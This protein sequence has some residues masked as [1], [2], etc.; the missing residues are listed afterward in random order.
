[1]ILRVKERLLARRD[2]ADGARF[3]I[4]GEWDDS[5]PVSGRL[6]REFA[7]RPGRKGSRTGYLRTAFGRNGSRGR[8]GY[9]RRNGGRNP[10]HIWFAV[11]LTE[12]RPEPRT[13][14]WVPD[15]ADSDQKKRYVSLCSAQGRG[16]RC[17]S[18]KCEGRSYRDDGRA[19][20]TYGSRE[21]NE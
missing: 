5:L 7:G 8:G 1:M 19:I 2:E 17:E 9:P 10:I 11:L 20:M 12:T 14:S 15:E 16:H 3:E 13:R 21:L 6:A 18:V 4:L